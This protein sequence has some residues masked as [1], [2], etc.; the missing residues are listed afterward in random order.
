M[1]F[2][3]LARSSLSQPCVQTTL[4]SMCI[5]TYVME[6]GAAGENKASALLVRIMYTSLFI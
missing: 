3:M 2:F 1:V 4:Y 5:G 6:S